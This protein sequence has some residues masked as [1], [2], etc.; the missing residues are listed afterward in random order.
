LAVKSKI[1]VGS[2]ETLEMGEKRCGREE[3]GEGM[4]RVQRGETKG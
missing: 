3:V 1:L 2:L 4:E